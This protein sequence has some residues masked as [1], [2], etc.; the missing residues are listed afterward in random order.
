MKLFLI[1][2]SAFL[3]LLVAGYGLSRFN[4]P[5]RVL[6]SE[7]QESLQGGKDIF[8]LDTRTNLAGASLKVKIPGAELY[9]PTETIDRLSRDLPKDK[10]IVVYCT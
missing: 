5:P 1:L 8:F 3:L 2:S 7:V 6:V 10:T 4:E 9:H